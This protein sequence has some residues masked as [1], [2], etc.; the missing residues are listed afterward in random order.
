M[1]RYLIV[2]LAVL[3]GCSGGSDQVATAGPDSPNGSNS[4]NDVEAYKP[5][6]YWTVYEY[7]IVRQQQ[8]GGGPSS[9]GSSTP[10][11]TADNYIPESEFLANIDWVEANLKPF[12]YDMVA[13]DGWGDTQRL[14]EHGYRASHSENWAERL[15]LV[16]RT[17]ALA[18]HAPRHVREPA[19]RARRSLGHHDE[20]RRY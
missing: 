5:P 15:R 11:A 13:I 8:S 9:T 6:L 18:R 20:N 2:C 1:I 14:S 4:P 17:P 12:G 10:G 16:V 7:H 19:R 3:C